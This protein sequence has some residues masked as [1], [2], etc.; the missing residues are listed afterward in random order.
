MSLL[1]ECGADPEA[2]AQKRDICNGEYLTCHQLAREVGFAKYEQVKTDA[3]TALVKVNTK[4]E[5]PD[6]LSW[7]KKYKQNPRSGGKTN[8][9]EQQKTRHQET[10]LSDMDTAKEKLVQMINEIE[11]EDQDKIGQ[12]L[13]QIARTFGALSVDRALEKSEGVTRTALLM[14]L[15]QIFPALADDLQ[16]LTSTPLGEKVE[17]MRSYLDAVIKSG[18]STDAN[19]EVVYV[20]GNTNSGKTSLVESFKHFIEEGE[21]KACLT[22]D[23]PKLLKTKVAELYKDLSLSSEK[24]K[25]VTV[26][27]K[28]RVNL[29]TFSE[30]KS[31][32]GGVEETQ[33]ESIDK[34]LFKIYDIG[35][36]QEY[37]NTSQLFLQRN[38]IALI[39]FDSLL[40]NSL[41]DSEAKF[42]SQVG[43]YIDLLCQKENK[44][45]K[46]ALVAT[47]VDQEA[48]EDKKKQFSAILQRAKGHIS[49][50]QMEDPVYLVDEVLR[51][52]AK[53]LSTESMMEL[54]RKMATLMASSELPHPP[55][56]HVPKIWFEWLE[57]LRQELMCKISELPP[58]PQ[59]SEDS[60]SSSITADEVSKLKALQQIASEP[61][62]LYIQQQKRDDDR[63]QRH[64]RG[65]PS[66]SS[67]TVI[68][69]KERDKESD[70]KS[71]GESGESKEESDQDQPQEKFSLKEDHNRTKANK[72]VM[73]SHQ[74][75]ESPP[76]NVLPALEFFYE[77][78]EILWYKE[79]KV[80]AR[81]IITDPM[82][83][84]NSLRTIINHDTSSAWP[85]GDVYEPAK[86]RL[87]HRGL[88]SMDD[89]RDICKERNK[90]SQENVLTADETWT[91][92]IELGIAISLDEE[93]SLAFIPCLISDDLE[94]SFRENNSKLERNEDAI[95]F[96]YE[97]DRGATTVGMFNRLLSSLAK[98]YLEAGKG[99]GISKAFSQKIEKRELGMIAGVSGVVTEQQDNV[100]VEFQ[101]IEFEIPTEAGNIKEKFCHPIRRGIR[102]HLL[103]WKR[104]GTQAT[105]YNMMK[106][107]N[108]IFAADLEAVLRHLICSECQARKNTTDAFGNEG[109]FHLNEQLQ[110]DGQET[111]RCSSENHL[112]N[113]RL[114]PFLNCSTQ[115]PDLRMQTLDEVNWQLVVF[116]T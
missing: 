62:L 70:K 28:E 34:C 88:L 42:Y 2:K 63:N 38:G 114:K 60:D 16:K 64:A 76:Q 89:F 112:L 41:A 75:E 81:I 46:V 90:E 50:L 80:L 4:K 52:S 57:N 105:A 77:M 87:L 79:K 115:P 12:I 83:L 5:K 116:F 30:D 107:I 44:G 20:L 33:K 67:K 98:E 15:K 61:N 58:L 96:Q 72:G 18:I 86:R 93:D 94:Q 8:P 97:F 48:D 29:V 21:A 47:K 109:V 31:A 36:H 7:T 99:G 69:D 95:C 53:E 11:V 40:L 104:D 85:K 59:S 56:K 92:M 1:V 32:T 3:L 73:A 103:Q 54:Y 45:L 106:K 9:G 84:I 35:G 17:D 43:T 78:S 39:C 51:T 102:I 100:R 27:Q 14:L 101:I 71:D 55:K 68:P 111:F 13:H 37:T 91:F 110:L 23:N 24:L 26:E 108:K 22:E 74:K 65:E 49:H 25:G 19:R 66:S 82:N 113:S 6:V 10:N